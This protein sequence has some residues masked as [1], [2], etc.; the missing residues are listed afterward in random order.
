MMNKSVKVFGLISIFI[1]VL[2]LTGLLE[3]SSET[4]RAASDVIKWKCQSHLPA[5]SVT[6]K[7]YEDFVDK[8]KR[9][10]NGKL[11]IELYPGGALVHSKE[12]FNAVRRG[13]LEM[14]TTG[15]GYI[16][17]QLPLAGISGGLPLNFKEVWECAYFTKW[18]GFEKMLRDAAAKYGI[19]YNSDIIFLAE[20]VLRKPIRTMEDFKGKKLRSTGVLKKY[21]TSIGAATSFISG[22]EL[23]TALASGVVDGCHWGAALG[24]DSIGLYEVCKYHLN[25]PL[26]IGTSSPLIFNQNAIDKLP[27]D[28]QD[29]LYSTVEERFWAFTN[30]NTYGDHKKL[31]EVQRERGVEVLKIPTEDYLKMQKA[32]IRIWDEE[33]KRSPECAKAVKMLKDFNRSLGRL[34]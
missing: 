33:A 5:A 19:Y 28:I 13:M 34:Q 18:L 12:I 21:L 4:A 16:R 6:Y 27:K 30:L 8:I 3:I 26:K 11:V 32:A 15:A 9:R 31:I 20:L 10:T 24:A 25:T 22:A 14:G 29:I 1:F 7:T 2:V 17:E 23:Y